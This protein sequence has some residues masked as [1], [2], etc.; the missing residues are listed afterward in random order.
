VAPLVLVNVVLEEE[1]RHEEQEW[2][3]E[4]RREEELATEDCRS[5]G[6]QRMTKQSYLDFSTSQTQCELREKRIDKDY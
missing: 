5:V 3:R 2:P 1:E 6:K 4:E